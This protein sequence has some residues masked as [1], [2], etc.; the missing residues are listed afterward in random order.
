MKVEIITDIAAEPV[1]LDEV[2]AFLRVTGSGHD[3]LLVKTM[4]G[5]REYLEKA[6]N[7]SFGEKVLKV[8]VDYEL[9][10]EL[11]PY[12]PVI[13]VTDEDSDDDYYYYTYEAGYTEL[14]EDLKTGLKM[15]IKH[16]YDADDISVDVPKV[17]KSIIQANDRNMML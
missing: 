1:T 7:L 11:L 13:D 8:T 2:K 14:P 12:G 17:I 5:A 6:T 16:W 15:V 10:E 9:P 4:K 3:A